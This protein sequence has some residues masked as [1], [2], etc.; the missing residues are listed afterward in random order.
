MIEIVLIDALL[1]FLLSP[2]PLWKYRIRLFQFV[3][4]EI[5]GQKASPRGGSINDYHA[6]RYPNLLRANG[7]KNKIREIF[8]YSK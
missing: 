2:A 5:L 3:E 6:A 7:I 8:S 4:G 1:M